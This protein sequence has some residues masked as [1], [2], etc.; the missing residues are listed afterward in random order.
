M[1]TALSLEGEL[2]ISA[3][4]DAI[5]TVMLRH[6]VLRT[7]FVDNGEMVVQKIS[8]QPLCA[9]EIEDTEDPTAHIRQFAG[10]PFDLEKGPLIRFQLLR[11]HNDNYLLVNMHH[12]ISDGWSIGLLIGELSALYNGNALPE[13][14]LQYGDYAFWQ[15]QMLAGETRDALSDW[16]RAHLEGAPGT[17]DLPMD[18][19]RPARQ[20][21]NGDV[22]RFSIDAELT[23]KLKSL[24]RQHN[25]TLFMVLE[26]AFALLMSRVSN[27]DDVL[28]GTPVANR[29]HAALEKLVGFF[30]NTVV[31]RSRFDDS[32]SY[33]RGTAPEKQRNDH[34][35]F[36]A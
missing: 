15:R 12:S 2:D 35:K 3:L 6:E 7:V 23:Q 14:T 30:V 19:P 18:F 22:V 34:E 1:P 27:Q 11:H 26:T 33:F 31:L 8:P 24:G 25:V 21:Y 36:R 9:L 4:K 20:T 16:W 13:L 28:I 5:S 10:A 32:E 17:L 29:H